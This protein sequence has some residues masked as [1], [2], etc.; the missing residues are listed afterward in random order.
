MILVKLFISIL[1]CS[2]AYSVKRKVGPSPIELN[3]ARILQRASGDINI[4]QA[5]LF[6]ERLEALKIAEPEVFNSLIE[7][8]KL[9]QA[10]E[11]MIMDSKV[12][13]RLLELTWDVIGSFLSVDPI[14]ENIAIKCH[15]VAEACLPTNCGDGNCALLD[16]GCG[17]GD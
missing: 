4:A 1:I 13:S 7:Q 15:K 12:H 6:D 8:R 3:A 5:I 2:L 10:D 14:D 9:Q 17:D 16:V 11:N